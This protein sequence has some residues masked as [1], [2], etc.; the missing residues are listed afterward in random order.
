MFALCSFN[1]LLMNIAGNH[2]YMFN[3]QFLFYNFAVTL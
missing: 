2:Y 3:V 1:S